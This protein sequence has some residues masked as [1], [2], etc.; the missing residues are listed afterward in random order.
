MIRLITNPKSWA[1]LRI[2]C[3][4]QFN[5]Q[6]QHCYLK[7]HS[8]MHAESTSSFRG[9]LTTILIADTYMEKDGLPKDFT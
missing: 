7:H 8:K 9:M 1:I 2:F 6:W 4:Q 5:H 3:I